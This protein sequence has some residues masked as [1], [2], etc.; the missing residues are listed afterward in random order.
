MTLTTFHMP[1]LD[2]VIAPLAAWGGDTD[3][4]YAPITP[5]EADRNVLRRTYTKPT[6]TTHFD[7]K[8]YEYV[9]GLDK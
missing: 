1:A 3:P 4:K 9:A 6:E 2:T 7:P 8:V 5:Y